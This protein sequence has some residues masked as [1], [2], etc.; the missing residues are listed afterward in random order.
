MLGVVS[1]FLVRYRLAFYPM[2][3]FLGYLAIQIATKANL[4]GGSVYESNGHP[5]QMKDMLSPLSIAVGLILMHS[6]RSETYDWS[7]VFWMG[8]T[9]VIVLFTLNSIEHIPRN[10]I[11]IGLLSVSAGLLALWFRGRFWN[12]TLVIAFIAFM[13]LF[14]A[15]AFPVMEL[16]LEAVLNEKLKK[17]GEKIRSHHRQM[18]AYYGKK[19]EN[20]K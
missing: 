2:L 5:T 15:L 16:V 7:W 10:A 6:G 17:V 9:L 20:N 11:A 19:L 18:E 8:E 14:V 4:R 13:A 1:V 3:L 12:Y